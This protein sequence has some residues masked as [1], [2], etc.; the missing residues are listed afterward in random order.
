VITIVAHE[1]SDK[2]GHNPEQMK[3]EVGFCR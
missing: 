2:G 1:R 3:P